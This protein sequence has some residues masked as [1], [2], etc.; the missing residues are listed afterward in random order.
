MKAPLAK[1]LTLKIL[2]AQWESVYH[3]QEA[4]SIF[5]VNL[6]AMKFSLDAMIWCQSKDDV[7]L[8]DLQ[9]FS[10]HVL[11]LRT[12]NQKLEC[13]ML[14]GPLY[15]CFKS[16]VHRWLNQVGESIEGAGNECSCV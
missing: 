3:L 8:Y 16:P 9:N 12:T 10:V 14:C 7:G 1:G 4:Y 6:N 5:S 15:E 11:L 13:T 2:V